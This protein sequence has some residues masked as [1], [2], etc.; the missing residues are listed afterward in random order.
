MSRPHESFNVS[1][2]NP[3]AAG[4]VVNMQ[5]STPG[6]PERQHLSPQQAASS[7]PILASAPGPSKASELPL[8]GL[9]EGEN[10][11]LFSFQQAKQIKN[12]AKRIL[13]WKRDDFPGGQP[14]SLSMQN[15]TELFRNAYVACEKTDGVRFLLLGTNHRLYLIGRRN[16]VREVADMYLPRSLDLSESQEMTL[17]DG[18]LVMDFFEIFDLEAIRR[19]ALR[20]P[21]PSDGI[22]F[23]PVKLPYVTGTCPLLLKWKPPHLNTVDFSVEPVYDLDGVPQIFILCA[24]Y[25]GVRTFAGLILAPY[26][27]FY[28][29]LYDMACRGSAGGVIVECFW[30]PTAPV[31]TFYPALRE[32]P[33]AR[34][35]QRWNSRNQGHPFYDFDRGEW[36]EGGWVAERIR[37]D[38]A[39]P[40]DVKVLVSVKR[41]IDDGVSFATLQHQIERFK[42]HKKRRV[43]ELCKGVAD[44]PIMEYSS[45]ETPDLNRT[46]QLFLFPVAVD[47]HGFQTKKCSPSAIPFVVATDEPLL[48]GTRLSYFA[49][50]MY[51]HGS[52]SVRDGGEYL[53]AGGEGPRFLR[54]A[55]D[56]G[57]VAEILN[58]LA[59]FGLSVSQL[60]TQLG[61]HHSGES[62]SFPQA[63]P[64]ARAAELF[65]DFCLAASMT[66]TSVGRLQLPMLPE[67]A[68]LLAAC[69]KG[70]TEDPGPPVASAPADP[71]A[72]SALL[73]QLQEQFLSLVSHSPDRDN[74]ESGLAPTLARRCPFHSRAAQETR[75]QLHA[76]PGVARQEAQRQTLSN[77]ARAFQLCC[78][79]RCSSM[80]YSSFLLLAACTSGRRDDA[81]LRFLASLWQLCD[82]ADAIL[83]TIDPTN[84]QQWQAC[85]SGSK[86]SSLESLGVTE[87]S[88][89]INRE[90]TDVSSEFEGG[91]FGGPLPTE[92]SSSGRVISKSKGG[93]YA[94]RRLLSG[95][96]LSRA[97]PKPVSS[98]RV[99]GTL[100]EASE[101]GPPELGHCALLAASR[102]QCVA[103]VRGFICSLLPA[104]LWAFLTRTLVPP[105]AQPLPH[106]LHFL[107]EEAEGAPPD[108][109]KGGPP[110]LASLLSRVRERLIQQDASEAG[111][112]G[113]DN[114]SGLEDLLL[115][116]AGSSE[117]VPTRKREKRSFGAV[118]AASAMLPQALHLDGPEGFESPEGNSLMQLLSTFQ[119][120]SRCA[121]L[122]AT[123]QQ[124]SVHMRTLVGL[125]PTGR[126]DAAAAG[127]LLEEGG[128][129]LAGASSEG[130]D[131]LGPQ[132]RF[133]EHLILQ[134]GPPSRATFVTS[135]TAQ[136]LALRVLACFSYYANACCWLEDSVATAAS[137][138]EGAFALEGGEVSGH[139]AK[140]PPVPA[141]WAQCALW[142]QQQL[143]LG[144]DHHAALLAGGL[145]EALANPQGFAPLTFEPLMP[146]LLLPVLQQQKHQ[147]QQQGPDASALAAQAVDAAFLPLDCSCGGA[148]D[149]A[150]AGH[151]LNAAAATRVSMELLLQLEVDPCKT[152]KA[153]M[154]VG[155]PL[156][157]QVCKTLGA[158]LHVAKVDGSLRVPSWAIPLGGVES[159]AN[160]ALHAGDQWSTQLDQAAVHAASVEQHIQACL[161]EAKAAAGE[162]S[163]KTGRQGGG[164]QSSASPRD[165]RFPHEALQQQLHLLL[166]LH[167]T[168]HLSCNCC[169]CSY[170][171]NLGCSLLGYLV[172]LSAASYRKSLRLCKQTQPSGCEAPPSTLWP[173]LQQTLVVERLQAAAR[174]CMHKAERDWLPKSYW[175]FVALSTL[176]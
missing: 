54:L 86:S 112:M 67:A 150:A 80:L 167:Q 38:K 92:V 68:P 173:L 18:E 10:P 144:A 94:L 52:L 91:T 114:S 31:F 62:A 45:L 37:T 73:R 139:S 7:R 5:R 142:A 51:S 46:Q 77:L 131:E 116:L 69:G 56:D 134:R 23:T 165:G 133:R 154:P 160:A 1:H 146:Q 25:R 153:H 30:R 70:K 156:M 111:S 58:S 123:Q 103:Y 163:K 71:V 162:G 99:K 113:L 14:V 108:E 59:V 9:L 164:R 152:G 36:R 42:Q 169:C 132:Q 65:Q 151:C 72:L 66:D 8:P 60:A 39:M 176:V 75:R 89:A 158:L 135:E 96:S 13:K 140:G 32:K 101:V 110:Y 41:S 166:M 64:A 85:A 90:G 48:V 120:G 27:E 76:G 129:Y 130:E 147:Q 83:K 84:P 118:V 104:L 20:L 119:G 40:N 22:I 81:F 105:K 126:R 159:P 2:H 74:S 95:A 78:R 49:L 122:L 50:E 82:E 6:P 141:A 149:E 43:A 125:A 137:L 157:L 4:T 128:A 168:Q 93:G 127:K 115:L 102:C 19:L 124:R 16:E 87:A 33:S 171:D 148:G 172:D 161:K 109:E 170:T 15:V 117:G 88:S 44:I 145:A 57:L 29:E 79:V 26:G 97:G 53:E 107:L 47:F 55:L 175:A 34:E 12:I 61:C 21:H 35:E 121:S 106:L 155:E 3:L 143:L 24:S 136:E 17:L 100:P 63:S 138:A 174:S 28:K 98:F 11:S